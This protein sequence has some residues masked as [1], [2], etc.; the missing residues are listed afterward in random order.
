MRKMKDSGVEWLGDIPEHWEIIKLKYLTDSPLQYGANESGVE[1]DENL[2][3]YIRITDITSDNKLKEENKLS[4]PYEIARPYLLKNNDILFARSGATVGK[5]F[6]YKSKY[7]ISAFAGYLIKASIKKNVSPDFVY[8]YTLGSHYELWKDIVATQSTI[9]NIGADKYNNLIIALPPV[10]EQEEISAYLDR[11][12]T[13]I[14]KII[15]LKK[16]QTDLLAEY[17]KNIIT[18]TV[19]KGLDKNVKM[20]DSGVELVGKIPEHWNVEKL[21][22]H[23]SKRNIKNH[24]DDT[25]LSLYRELGIVPKDSRDDN[26]NATSEDTSDYKYVRIGDFVVNK[27]KAWQGSVAVSEYEGI[28]SP[29]YYVYEFTDNTFNRRYFH[30]L[31]RNK[32]Y[33]AEFMRLSGGVRTGQWD[34]PANALENILIIIPPTEEQEEIIKF[35]DRKCIEVD[36]FIDLKKQQIE[37]LKEY[38][39]TLIYEYVT[40]K[41]EL[42]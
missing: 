35:L 33:S 18:E 1:Y 37:L 32:T 4:L 24:N 15:E 16:Q 29:A 26:N 8:Y 25:V 20:K 2:P 22:F 7:S 17:K 21:K 40:G 19:T 42:N 14:D 31:L 9:Q 3:R 34:L 5:S 12:C 30:Y 38:R 10:K 13:E 27:M 36:K 23:L 11:K 6:I 39:K 28:V 41:K